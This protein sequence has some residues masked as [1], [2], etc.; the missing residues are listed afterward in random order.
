MTDH[1][2]ISKAE[3]EGIAKE[4]A[5]DGARTKRQREVESAFGQ[6]LPAVLREL[7][8]SCSSK[9][10]VLRRINNTLESNG[11]QEKVSRGTLYNWLGEVE[12]DE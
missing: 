3:Y 2:H 11:I 6:S 1:T 4:M 9:S 10:E 8:D 5:E 12:A 7:R